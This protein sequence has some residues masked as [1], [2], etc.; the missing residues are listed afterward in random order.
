M[1]KRLRRQ[2]AVRLT[3]KIQQAASR[4]PQTDR[5]EPTA[6]KQSAGAIRYLSVWAGPVLIVAAA[7]GM[8]IW[9]WGTWPDVLV[10]FGHQRY[11]PWRLTEGE[12]LYRDI[13]FYNGPLSQYF[14]ALMFR[15]FGAS[16]RT[17]EFCNLTLL[18]ALVAL[19][20]YAMRQVASRWATTAAC[21]VF[22]LLFAFGQNVGIGNYNYVCPYSHEMTHG[23]LLSLLAVVAAW[24]SHRH[25]LSLTV[26]SGL[27]LGLAF[28]TKAEVFVGGAAA[29]GTALVLGIWLERCRVQQALARLVCFLAAAIIPPAVAFAC[30]ASALPARQAW[31]GTMGS[32]VVAARGDLLEL[33]FFRIGMGTDNTAASIQAMASMTGLYALSPG[34]GRFDWFVAA[35]AG[36]RPISDLAV[37]LRRRYSRCRR[38]C[39]GCVAM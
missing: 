29:T 30:L 22:V 27:A 7:V 35:L 32:W 10:D 36:T 21:L 2:R 26:V 25:R 1:S 17:L 3:A 28:L 34:A 11:I 6:A 33:P 8:A 4:G 9:T 31:L 23:L 39:C 13:A 14:N 12:V 5:A 15:I 18:A 38:E 24:P 16:L 19:L 20:Y 37:E